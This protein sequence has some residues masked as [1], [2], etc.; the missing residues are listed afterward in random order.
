MPEFPKSETP[1]SHHTLT[2]FGCHFFKAPGSEE[3]W[4]KD[5]KTTPNSVCFDMDAPKKIFWKRWLLSNMTCFLGI[6]QFHRCKRA[7]WDPLYVPKSLETFRRVSKVSSFSHCGACWRKGAPRIFLHTY[8][9]MVFLLKLTPST[10]EVTFTSDSV[11]LAVS[12]PFFPQQKHCWYGRSNPTLCSVF[13]RLMVSK[14]PWHR[15]GSVK[16]RILR[17]YK[18]ILI[19]IPWTPLAYPF[20][21]LFFQHK[22]GGNSRGMGCARWKMVT[23][24]P[25]RISW[26][27]SNC[28]WLKNLA[29]KPPGMYPKN[30]VFFM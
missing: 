23:E 18:R 1:L 19:G 29:R 4:N 27:P 20:A 3:S 6:L 7:F 2:S 8:L 24:K 12:Q 25:L 17:T 16:S 21:P 26:D 13:R 10:Y 15:I 30:P 28:W 9:E 11:F 22:P 5:E 14:S